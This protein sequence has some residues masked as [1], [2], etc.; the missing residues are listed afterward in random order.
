MTKRKQKKIKIPWYL[1]PKDILEDILES[2]GLD[3]TKM[4]WTVV[5]EEGKR[6]YGVAG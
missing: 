6:H 1:V 5:L 4:K 3:P 2:T